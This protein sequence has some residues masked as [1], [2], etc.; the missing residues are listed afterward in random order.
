MD[1]IAAGTSSQSTPL[2]L[3]N[4]GHDPARGSVRDSF[5]GRDGIHQ[6]AAMKKRPN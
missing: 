4:Y 2:L 6:N 5:K 3:D 1:E